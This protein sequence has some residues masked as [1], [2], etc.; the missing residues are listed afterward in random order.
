MFE[1]GLMLLYGAAVGLMAGTFGGILAALAGV[2]GGLIYVPVFYALM[3]HG[4]GVSLPVLGSMLAIVLT[5]GFSARSH[6]RLGHVDRRTTRDMAPWLML[7]AAAGLWST[8]RLPEAVVLGALACL[9]LWVALD[10]GRS[11]RPAAM[12]ANDRLNRMAA[13]PIGYVSGLLGIGGGTMLVPLLRRSL[14]LRQ[15]VGTSAMCGVLMAIGATVINLAG[16]PRWHEPLAGQASF[17]AGA[18]LGILL[19][20]PRTT[21][22]AARL[23][24]RVAESTMRLL[25]KGL[26]LALATGLGLSAVWQGWSS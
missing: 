6:L 19:I 15:A 21:H 2:G 9:D 24:D 5:G 10:Y 17:L 12:P 22:W 20:L 26:F 16:E 25:L 14:P 3:P 23:H 18:L 11:I 13:L 1:A 4:D 8:L 7:G